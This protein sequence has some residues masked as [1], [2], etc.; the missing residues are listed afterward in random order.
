MT[1]ALKY[2]VVLVLLLVIGLGMWKFGGVGLFK[3]PEAN[4]ISSKE[5]ILERME[6]V[7]KL[8]TLEAY[9]SEVYPHKDYYYYD[10]SPFRKKALIRV[11]A[12]VSVGYD[13]QDIHMEANDETKTVTIYGLPNPEILS[14]DHDLDYYDISEGTFNSFT[15][16]DYNK[17]NADAK[18]FI[19]S[20]AEA[21]AALFEEADE[22]KEELLDMFRWMLSAAGWELV[23]PEAPEE[24]KILEKAIK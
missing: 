23:V 9:Y 17:L 13:F 18:S 11:K 6:K 5:I 1:K 21:N 4:V 15:A 16:S 7:N 3:A 20:S 10:I 2:L 14:I 24:V 22:K 8:I 12:K 19:R